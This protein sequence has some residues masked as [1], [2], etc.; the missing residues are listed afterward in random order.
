MLRRGAEARRDAPVVVRAYRAGDRAR[1]R[2]I[3]YLTRCAASCW[4]TSCR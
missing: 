2:E 3:A 4:K 1:V